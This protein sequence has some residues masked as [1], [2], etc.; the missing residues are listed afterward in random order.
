[1]EKRLASVK[2][3]KRNRRTGE[4]EKNWSDISYYEGKVE[5]YKK[6]LEKVK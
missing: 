3:G 6:Y 2:K 4:I 5:R 1:M